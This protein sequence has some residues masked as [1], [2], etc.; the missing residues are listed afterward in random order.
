[1]KRVL[2]IA[3]AMLALLACSKVEKNPVNVVKTSSGEEPLLFG[4]YNGRALTKAGKVG[5]L[6]TDILKSADAGFGV[7][8][9]YTAAKDFNKTSGSSNLNADIVPNFLYNEKVYWDNSVS[10]WTY[11]NLK[12]WPNDNSDADNGNSTGSTSSSKISFFS[13]APYV[14]ETTDFTAETSGIVGLSAN[15]QAGNPCVEYQID[16]EGNSIDLLWGTAGDND[17]DINGNSQPGNYVQYNNGTADVDA[18]YKTNVNLVKMKTGGKVKFLFKHALAQI[19]GS[20]NKTT[21]ANVPDRDSEGAPTGTESA[22]TL[23]QGGLQVKLN[24]DDVSGGVLDANTIVTVKKITISNDLDGDGDVDDDDKVDVTITDPT[25]ATATVTTLKA[26]FIS[27]GTLDLATGIWTA[28]TDPAYENG[29]VNTELLSPAQI[30]ED[31]AAA[32]AAGTSYTAPTVEMAQNIREPENVTAFN[33]LPIGV[34]TT[35]QNVF[36]ST[37]NPLVLMP[38]TIPVLR[39]TITYIVRSLDTKLAQKY[40]EV[41]QTISKIIY[42][43]EAIQINK[44]YNIIIGLGLTSVKFEATVS[45][46][47]PSPVAFDTSTD[48]ATPIYGYDTTTGDPI[49]DPNDPRLESNT[50]VDLPINVVG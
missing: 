35:A 4:S 38:G 18:L 7:F 9:F 42:L 15:T 30:A 41:E 50:Y 22:T 14:A 1:M 19:G 26:G 47:G 32:T 27:R 2:L 45:D 49:T 37:A 12:Y 40:T 3:S 20:S 36:E 43:N 39:V 8:A 31:Q 5:D 6:T 13:Y 25:T 28:N 16:S 10:L 34:L 24:V 17:V 48:P 33:Q 11:D 23:K 46:W 44:Q 29:A 21:T